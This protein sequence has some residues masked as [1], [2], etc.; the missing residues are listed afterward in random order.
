M[1]L[2]KNRYVFGGLALLTL[3]DAQNQLGAIE[4]NKML[5]P[6]ANL[7]W[8]LFYNAQLAGGYESIIHFVLFLALF[9]AIV[10]WMLI[11]Q[12]NSNLDSSALTRVNRRNYWAKQGLQLFVIAAVYRLLLT[13]MELLIVSV[14][15][16]YLDFSLTFKQSETA[17]TLFNQNASLQLLIYTVISVLGWGIWALLTYSTCLFVK[18]TILVIP[19]ALLVSFAG[20]VL[21]IVI[22]QTNIPVLYD[23]AY[24][25]L[26]GNVQAPGV[27]TVNGKLRGVTIIY[28]LISLIFYAGLS[29]V[30]ARLYMRKAERGLLD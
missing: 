6:S 5:K 26:F 2:V 27:M 12:K 7:A 21:P 18:R 30:A 17:F 13:A 20:S 24:A 22:A 8:Q 14:K 16:G 9:P 23:F 15:F 10:S 3:V 19:V 28:P 11:Y 29:V 4:A 25:L 1:N